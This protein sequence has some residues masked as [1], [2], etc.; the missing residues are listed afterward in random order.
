MRFF[1]VETG[2]LN[3]IRLQVMQALGQP[4]GSAAEPWPV[5]GAF[6]DGA[7]GYVALGAHHTEGEFA[8]L[9]DQFIETPG[10]EEINETGYFAAMPD[11]KVTQ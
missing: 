9:M 3:A 8:P 1:K 5:D 4:N 11:E 6:N 2:A 7:Q 10:V